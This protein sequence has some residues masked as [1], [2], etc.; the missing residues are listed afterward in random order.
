MLMCGPV[1]G[2]RVGVVLDGCHYLKVLLSKTEGKPARPSEQVCDLQTVGFGL[3]WAPGSEQTFAGRL[4]DPL[5]R[6]AD[7]QARH[8]EPSRHTS[9][10]S[11]PGSGVNR[12]AVF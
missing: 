3:H 5:Q 7:S 8:D 2:G 6:V 4:A 12:P 11:N 10:C 9:R 1:G